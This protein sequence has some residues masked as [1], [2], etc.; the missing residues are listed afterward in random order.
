MP[1]AWPG[2]A[3]ICSVGEGVLQ[4]EGEGPPAGPD[5]PLHTD[6]L[7]Y[8]ANCLISARKAR[9]MGSRWGATDPYSWV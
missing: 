4:R 9:T 3:D 6:G 1:P 2:G 5:R 7:N 8:A